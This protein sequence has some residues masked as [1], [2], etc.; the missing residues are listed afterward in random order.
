[1]VPAHPSTSHSPSS[2]RSPPGQRRKPSFTGAPRLDSGTI[3]DGTAARQDALR[4]DALF[5][6]PSQVVPRR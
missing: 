3:A 1:L 4:N 2:P 6:Y 5:P